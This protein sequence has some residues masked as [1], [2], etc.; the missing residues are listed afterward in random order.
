MR[1]RS[2]AAAPRVRA[3]VLPEARCRVKA[4]SADRADELE[5]RLQRAIVSI[6][7]FRNPRRQ[8][9]PRRQNTGM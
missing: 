9:Q 5:R 4:T 7:R 3:L 6:S 1:P 8:Q 2:R